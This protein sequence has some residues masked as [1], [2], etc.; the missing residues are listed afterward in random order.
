MPNESSD[1][2]HAPQIYKGL[3]YIAY[4]LKGIVGMLLDT[5]LPQP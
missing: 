1:K 4:S 2:C 5:L 3:F